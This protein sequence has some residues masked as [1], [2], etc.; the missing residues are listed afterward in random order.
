VKDLC[1]V[2]TSKV[3]LDAENL[4]R[5]DDHVSPVFGLVAS[6]VRAVHALRGLNHDF[7]DG[8]SNICIAGIYGYVE[9]VL[10]LAARFV[11]VAAGLAGVV[12]LDV[13]TE[14]GIELGLPVT[15]EHAEFG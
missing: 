5:G 4:G 8:L 9:A 15:R 2:G 13:E 7:V 14:E 3:E 1:P 6:T 10:W 12:C 11:Q